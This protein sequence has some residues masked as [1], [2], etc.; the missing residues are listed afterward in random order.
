MPVTS[1]DYLWIADWHNG[2]FLNGYCLTFVR[3]MVPGE[4]LDDLG[5]GERS[6]FVGASAT[7]EPAY[8]AWSIHAERWLLV[9][10]TQV[11][12]WVL[13]FEANGSLGVTERV[14]LPVSAE[15]SVVSH[16]RNVNAVDH[17]LWLEDGTICVR[18]EP[19][20]PTI[21]TGTHAD[22][23]VPELVDAGFDMRA[24]DVRTF[25]NH[26]AATFAL[27]ERITGV[28]VTP[29]LLDGATFAGGLAPMPPTP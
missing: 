14:M 17:F 24:D 8:D 23:I 11:D 26:T 20:F 2:L 10:V 22:A 4:L 6:H 7:V 15:T 29:E 13:M 12:Q 1:A 28:R 19:L 3:G 18:F 16:F 25:E 27:G 5:V 9:A 21:R